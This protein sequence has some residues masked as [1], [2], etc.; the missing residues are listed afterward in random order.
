MV[1]AV[2]GFHCKRIAPDRYVYTGGDVSFEERQSPLKNHTRC[3]LLLPGN[4]A[5][6]NGRENGRGGRG[7][8]RH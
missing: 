1:S 3:F 6:G 4:E 8:L 2:E 5:R 7:E